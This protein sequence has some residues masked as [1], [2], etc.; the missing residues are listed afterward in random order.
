[1]PQYTLWLP[2]TYESYRDILVVIMV[3]QCHDRALLVLLLW[4]ASTIC[5]P[6]LPNRDCGELSQRQLRVGQNRISPNEVSSRP[7]DAHNQETQMLDAQ[8]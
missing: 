3:Q 1:M 7:A 4:L 5:E 6:F 8:R 2:Q